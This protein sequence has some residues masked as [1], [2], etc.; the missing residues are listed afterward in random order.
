MKEKEERAFKFN[1]KMSFD[2]YT[3]IFSKLR[4]VRM[5]FLN[6]RVYLIFEDACSEIMNILSNGP[7]EQFT[8]GIGCPFSS[9][10]PFEFFLTF[11]GK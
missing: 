1:M 8:L 6:V 5:S 4:H 10:R 9:Y 11:R 2:S 3:N 7:R